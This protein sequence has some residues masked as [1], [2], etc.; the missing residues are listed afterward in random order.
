MLGHKSLKTTQIYS[1]V[2]EVKLS[3]DMAPIMGKYE[4]NNLK[5]VNN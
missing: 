1:K 4:N 2:T 5:I 3:D